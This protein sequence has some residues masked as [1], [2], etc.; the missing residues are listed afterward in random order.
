MRSALRMPIRGS[1][2]H[3]GRTIRGIIIQCRSRG[4]CIMDITHTHTVMD[5]GVTIIMGDTDTA[6]SGVRMVPYY[7]AEG[8]ESVDERI[9]AAHRYQL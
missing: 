5:T 1:M 7:L 2:I 4:A 9:R 8:M 6:V 3:T